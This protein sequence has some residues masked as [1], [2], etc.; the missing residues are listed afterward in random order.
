MRSFSNV[1]GRLCSLPATLLLALVLGF[2]PLAGV[3]GSRQAAA[4]TTQVALFLGFGSSP[5]TDSGMDILNTMLSAVGIPHY[6]GMVF[7]WGEKQEAFDWIQQQNDLSTLVLIGHSFGANSALQLSNNFLL[8]EGI[9]V[10]LTVQID[11]VENFDGG[12]NDQ[13]PTNVEVGFNYYQK[14][15]FPQ[16]ERDV[17]G[18]TNIDAEELFNDPSI[19]HTSL[20]DDSRLHDLIA[21]HILDNLNLE[22]ADFDGNGYIDGNDFLLWQRGGSP[23]PLSAADL[24]LWETQYGMAFPLSAVAAVPEPATGLILL[25]GMATMLTGI[26]TFL[27]KPIR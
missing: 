5:N 20:D 1:R 19:T 27:S 13:L 23:N 8:G 21:Q 15:G 6:A 10:D 11:S 4:G 14:G 18:A 17:Q 9:E 26:R 16:G 12:W 25:I 2:V 3:D 24:N 22:N 7:R